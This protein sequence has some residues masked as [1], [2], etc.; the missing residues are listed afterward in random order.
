MQHSGT[1]NRRI[2]R[3]DQKHGIMEDAFVV[4]IDPG[5]VK[6]VPEI[7]REQA[8]F[9]N[10]TKSPLQVFPDGGPHLF[11]PGRIAGVPV[12]LPDGNSPEKTPGRQQAIPAGRHLAAGYG[13][14]LQ[15][16]GGDFDTIAGDIAAAEQGIGKQGFVAG[17]AH[18]EG[19]LI[20][21]AIGKSIFHAQFQGPGGNTPNPV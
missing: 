13:E 18:P 20:K 9:I 19:L 14:P 1:L 2:N 10:K 4:L 7:G 16:L 21:G 3:P 12:M 8:L 5:P 15:R 6:E 11:Q 17:I